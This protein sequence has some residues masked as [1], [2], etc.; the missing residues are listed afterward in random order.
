[1]TMV[2]KSWSSLSAEPI[3]EEAIRAL[4]QP[5]KKFKFY[6]NTVEPGK[7]MTTKAGHEFVLYVLS[8]I[9]KTSLEGLELTLSASE[10]ITFEKGS[11]VF[12]VLGDQEL[13]VMKVFSLA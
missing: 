5:Q 7:N 10:L 4:H 12:D 3:S 13:K 11:Y 8:G 6:V 9:C 1:M 2:K